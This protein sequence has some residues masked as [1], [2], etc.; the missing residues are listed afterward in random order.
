M[1]LGCSNGVIDLT[2]GEHRP[3]RPTDYIKTFAPTPWLGL[4]APAPL[5]AQFLAEIFAGD[6]E[7]ISYIQRLLGYGITGKTT[8]H[9]LPIFYGPHG[10]NGKGT[11]LETVGRVL[12][13][14]AGPI[15]A[16]MLLLQTHPR[17]GGAPTSD[18]MALRGRR[19]VWASETGEGRHLDGGS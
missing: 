8:E 9:I 18:I 10:R 16:E 15:E 13:E 14:I 2:S 11:L 5:W 19:L 17:Q 6:Q 7:L 12:G 3:G 1:L 4:D